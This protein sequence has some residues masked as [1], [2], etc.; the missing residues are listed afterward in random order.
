MNKIL[1]FLLFFFN[2]LIFSQ[3]TNEDKYQI[4]F[5][6]YRVSKEE[7][8]KIIEKELMLN[9]KQLD[10]IEK[11]VLKLESD[12]KLEFNR[13]INISKK[14]IKAVQAKVNRQKSILTASF[15]KILTYHQL[16]KWDLESDNWK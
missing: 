1:T 10:E 12:N 13:V 6:V 16:K 7:F 14:N 15:T 2:V 9:K 5:I 3:E 4:K 8:L 11:I